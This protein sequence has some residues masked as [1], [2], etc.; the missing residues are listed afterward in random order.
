MFCLKIKWRK[1]KEQFFTARPYYRKLIAL[2]A[3]V[4]YCLV[5]VCLAESCDGAKHFQ[6]VSGFLNEVTLHSPKVRAE[7]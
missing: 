3:Q 2:S 7:M 1:F 4:K 6:S 5:D